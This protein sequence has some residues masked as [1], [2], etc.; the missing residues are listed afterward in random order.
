MR[1]VADL[2]VHS[3]FSRATSPRMT[4]EGLLRA[5]LLKGVDVV[6]TG[7]LTHPGWRAELLPALEPAEPGFLR[8]RRAAARR[9][10]KGLPR[11]LAREARFVLSGEISC[12][13]RRAGR[14]RKV[15]L[16]LLAPSFDAA[17]RFAAALGRRGNLAADG[18][19]VLGLDAEEAA[20]MALDAGLELFPAHVFTPHF[21]LLGA[22]SAFASAG[23][24][25]GPVAAH[26]LAMETGL[27]AD[28]PMCRRV[29]ALDRYPLVSNSDA[30]S[31]E[32]LAREA[33][34]FDTGFDY[35]SMVGAVR[36]GEGFT[37]TLEFFPEE[38]KYHLDGHRGC[39]VILAPAE[40]RAL[41]GR[42]PVC[43]RPVTPGVL[44]RVE[45]LA[46][47]GAAPAPEG[48][49]GDRPPAATPGHVKLVPLAELVAESMRAASPNE[50]TYRRVE[51]LVAEYGP[52]LSIL[53]EVPVADL[54]P[55]SELLALAVGRMREGRV[56]VT[57]GYDGAYGRVAALEPEGRNGGRDV[58]GQLP[59]F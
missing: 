13:Y 59:L 34:R 27:S 1:Y 4:P 36:C 53:T 40:S 2:H 20:A 55:A 57:P 16:C 50:A 21:S 41:E 25:F 52:E 17:E 28:P 33:N 9:A 37:G 48:R 5:C 22:G 38:G 24:A 11:S 32:R 19:P 45:A 10:A 7:D 51:A 46:A 30:H 29:P 35:F 15:H 44:A 47:L 18:R 26:L 6:G 23:E 43:G 54:E 8:A 12:I 58:A 39:G 14:T 49:G 3:H 56:A 31:P 42:C